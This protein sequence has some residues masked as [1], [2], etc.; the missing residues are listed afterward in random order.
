MKTNYDLAIVIGRFQPFH[1]GHLVT[2]INASKQADRVLVL[3]GSSFQP[4]TIK[5]PFDFAERRQMILESAKDADVGDVRVQP[6][7]DYL[8]EDNKWATQVD[9]IAAENVDSDNAKI[10]IVGHD[11]DESTYYLKMFPQFEHVDPGSHVQYD[12][13]TIDATQLRTLMFDNQ[14]SF[15]QGATPKPVFNFLVEF[16][17]TEEHAQLIRENDFI[18][19]YKKQWANSP[20]PPS[21]NTVDAVVVQGGHVLLVKRKAE[22]GRGLWA[23]PGGFVD[24][25]ETLEQAV[26]RELKEE[27]RI[28]V[29]VP[30]I[31]SNITYRRQ[32]DH[33]NRS[34]R[35]RTF[36]EA[37]LIELDLDHNGQL[38]KVK[39][40]DD[41]EKAQWISINDALE[42][43][44]CLF[45]D[46]HSI[47]STM[48]A[49]TK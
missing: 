43:S 9:R 12:N 21:F 37:F 15:L 36:S 4:R 3:V 35:G 16:A 8:Y 41:A 25:H 18:N 28:S 42:M 48:V 19:E 46:H 10:C 38:A 6:L 49:R 47:I 45:E 17:K 5:N 14:I 7:R 22:P 27:T 23:L 39:G 34:L 44:G 24:P 2:L 26:I 32:F 40:S 29:P 11:K 20:Y 33:P 30:I 13:H 1:Y 31:K